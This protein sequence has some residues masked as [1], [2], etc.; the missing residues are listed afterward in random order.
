[1]KKK[2]LDQDPDVLFS[3]T[4]TSSNWGQAVALQ[5]GLDFVFED[6]IEGLIIAAEYQS[7]NPPELILQGQTKGYI[8]L[9]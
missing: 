3:G 9:R 5:L 4:G 2:L 6:F 7:E 1:M 8:G